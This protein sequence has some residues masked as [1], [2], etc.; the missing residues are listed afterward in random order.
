MLQKLLRSRSL[1]TMVLVYVLIAASFVVMYGARNAAAQGQRTNLVVGLQLDMPNLDYFDVATNTIWKGYQLQFNWEPLFTFDP[2]Y[3]LYADLADP[4]RGGT[5]CPAGSVG[6]PGYCV[7]A[8]GLN[9]TVYIRSGVT[10][11]NGQPMTADD[12]IF[13]YQSLGWSTYANGISKG[14]WWPAPKFPL[15]NSTANG[16]TCTVP[17]GLPYA[18]S[19]HVGVTKIDSTTVKFWFTPHNLPGGI[20]GGYAL[21]F[22]DTLD[23]PIIPLQ[24]W[25]TH[26]LASGLANYS[27]SSGGPVTDTWDRSI[28]TAYG[29]GMTQSDATVG[30]GPF[31][32]TSW[33]K[34]SGSTISVYPNYWGK[35]Q[36]HNWKGTSYGF[37]PSYLTA[38]NFVV[39]GSL[40][41]V[42]LALQKGEIDTML[43]S[44]T[45]G[46]LNQIRSN[47][48]I[49]P[50][51]SLDSGFFYMSF[52]LIKPPWNQLVLREA[53]SMAIDKDYI[54]N[55]L[56]GG[57]GTKGT[58][59]ISELNFNYVNQ[60]ASPPSFDVQGGI[61]L[62]KANGY[63]IDP[64]TGFFK[65]PSGNPI[66]ATILTPPKDYDP[67]RAD[68]GIMI[69]NNLKAMHLDIDAA[70]TSFN[71]IVA[72]FQVAPITYDIYI[73]GWSL[74]PFPEA[75]ICSFFCSDQA[76]NINPSGSNSAQY[77]KLVV[78]QKI[79]EAL[80]TIDATKR[81]QLIKD[82][83]GI[84]VN[85]I[86]WNV[87]YYRKN[88]GAYRNDVFAGWVNFPPIS[89]ASFG[90][91]NFYTIVNLHPAGQEVIPGSTGTLT[92]TTSM[93]DQVYY[94][95]SVPI[96]ALVSQAGAPVS[97][98]GVTVNLT[99]GTYSTELTGTTDTSGHA[100]FTWTVPLIQG[101]GVA[102]TTATSGTIS[103]TNQ[104]VMEAT[105][106]PPLPSAQLALSTTRP[107]IRP[108][109]TSTI[110]ATVTDSAGNGI[111][112]V[113][114]QIDSTL[115]LGTVVPTQAT[116]AANGV[117]SFVYH[118]PDNASLFPN[119]HLTDVVKANVSVANTVAA[120]TQ[121][122]SIVMVV[123][124]GLAPIWN[125]TAVQS[126]TPGFVVSPTTPAT[127][128][129]VNVSDF[130]GVPQVGVHVD[131]LTSDSANVT[132][133]NTAPG[134]NI[135]DALGL[136]SFTVT[137]TTAAITG[138][139]NTNVVLTFKPHANAFAT[140]DS[141][142][143]LVSNGTTTPGIA[144]QITFS[145]RMIPY[146]E[147][148]QTD[149]VS[150]QVW[151]QTGAPVAN[152]PVIFHIDY[153]PFGPPAQF[154]FNMPNYGFTDQY[155]GAWIDEPNYTGGANFDTS[156]L[157]G[158]SL[159]GTFE[160]SHGQGAAYGLENTIED[161][162]V[163]G[164]GPNLATGNSIDSCDPATWPTGFA[165]T[166]TVN[167]T[168]QTD[169][170][171]FYNSSFFVDQEKLDSPIQVQAFIGALP[172]KT[173]HL[174]I[175][176][177]TP[178][179]FEVG[180]AHSIDSGIV[181]QRAPIF[182]L[183]QVLTTVPGKSTPKAIV[184]SQSSQIELRAHFYG[185]D[186]STVSRPVVF[187]TQGAGSAGRNVKGA[188][189]GALSKANLADPT[190][191]DGS[192]NYSGWDAGWF[193]Y[194]RTVP[195]VSISQALTF[196]Y[197]PADSRF[198]YSGKEQLYGGDYGDYWLSPTF[199]V[200]NAK[201]PFAMTI[202][203]LYLPT[204][205]AFLK[206]SLA[207]TLL[208]AGG[209]TTATVTVFSSLTG[210]PI[211]GASVWSGSTQVVTN[212]TGVATLTVVASTLGA[213]EGLVVAS[214]PYGGTARGW[215]AYVASDPVLTYSGLSITKGLAGSASTI[216]VTVTNTLAVAGTT[217]VW[218]SIDGNNSVAQ[219]VSIAASGSKA[220]TFSYVF[221]D[222]GSHT[223]AVGT[224][225]TSVDIQ[226]APPPDN[227]LL[228]AL[229]IALLVVGVVAGVVV[230]MMLARRGKKPPTS[231]PEDTGTKPAEEEIGPEEQL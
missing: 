161:F 70:P 97:G 35:A 84:V 137:E 189:A 122:A 209:N 24:V 98:A 206:V 58:V 187:L 135:T 15:W 68:A 172:G 156:A 77:N 226:A 208:P 94:R 18:C 119:Q 221:T 54:V 91:F 160:S 79:N 184:T 103:G 105:I 214:T 130:E 191:G 157:G 163:I 27:D 86:P 117:A 11:T 62:L 147:T 13:T 203:Y 222:A 34:N 80:Y 67:V 153:G 185:V 3:A 224:Q 180:F 7:D 124:N 45:P 168:S 36:V 217:T 63:T 196:T 152:V 136:A 229:A 218:L 171:G 38:V 14:I 231:A 175:S 126:A 40:D 149:D 78:D 120:D 134:S 8:S 39:Y 132:V 59:P 48:A 87:L 173:A 73:L 230:G 213:T 32:L 174:E 90:V 186:G 106:G 177:C 198:A 99:F 75:Y 225:S 74:G 29:A 52:N 22:Y 61:N 12:V 227:T 133:T 200:L 69:S 169:A 121:S 204:T 143:L 104:K 148:Q 118:A 145:N 167:A 47:P 193:N 81:Q 212:T 55:T 19:S 46:F 56:L 101:S 166:Y 114:V 205:T 50:Y 216:V 2:D 17:A 83:E 140:S 102:T 150:V 44:V 162:E 116:T 155:T 170:L 188:F 33:A 57:F 88:L 219:V 123:Q 192:T 37:S 111:S 5:A 21:A 223:V 41:V 9:I 60:S 195:G 23:M 71:T 151:D 183:G 66:K 207:Q 95:E 64:A 202:A 65:D 142:L 138:L 109:G 181:T 49:T 201:L 1:R 30:T 144:A 31:M 89:S 96:S 199:E 190:L 28:D 164:D 42:S 178:A 139:H 154:P 10:F 146:S 131:N 92:V 26:M 211:S 112:G 53:I 85:D 25:K 110:T 128:I 127:V 179:T 194:T 210:A 129:I 72:K 159:G 176:P 215:F 115:V 158:G 182:A 4:A 197:L 51:Q 228:Y 93:P 6:G 82:V 113:P 20:V 16:G 108:G 107:V 43:W 125:I 165:G 220:L 76:T 141:V 100:S